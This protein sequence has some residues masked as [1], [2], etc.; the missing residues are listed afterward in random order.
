VA[1]AGRR[2]CLEIE[3]RVQRERVE[4]LLADRTAE[5][6]DVREQLKPPGESPP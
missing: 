5:L 2:R 4:R 6:G 3:R 1:N